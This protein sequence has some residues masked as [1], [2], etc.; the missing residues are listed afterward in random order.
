MASSGPNDGSTFTSANSGFAWTNPSNAETSNNVR[1]IAILDDLNP[2]SQELT[3]V[4]FVLAIPGGATID[5]IQVDIEKSLAASSQPGLITIQDL[6]VKLLKAGVAHGSNLAD[7]GTAWGTVD[8]YKTYGGPADLWGGTWTPDDINDANFGTFI[9]ARIDNG[10]EIAPYFCSGRV[11]HMRIT[12]TY[13]P[14]T[15]GPGGGPARFAIYD[16]YS[17]GWQ[18]YKWR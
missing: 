3:A 2:E 4:G 12:V 8:A 16:K 9:K 5:G 15:V 13:T 1:A 10:L 11:D 14:T 6:V 7:I 17:Y 18:E